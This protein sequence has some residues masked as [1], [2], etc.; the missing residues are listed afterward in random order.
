MHLVSELP[1]VFEQVLA[2]LPSIYIYIRVI[3]KPKMIDVG[4]LSLG[5]KGTG[6]ISWKPKTSVRYR[7]KTS[8]RHVHDRRYFL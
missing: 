2:A 3:H 5:E 6:C 1:A 8:I 7:Y 4:E